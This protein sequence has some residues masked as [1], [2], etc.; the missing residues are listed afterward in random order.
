[1]TQF[2]I[3]TEGLLEIWEELSSGVLICWIDRDGSSMD[4]VMTSNM[5]SKFIFGEGG[6]FGICEE[7]LRPSFEESWKA[8]GR[9]KPGVASFTGWGEDKSLKGKTSS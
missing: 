2:D 6:I 3:L 1:M 7:V 5:L 9:E 8:F 4:W